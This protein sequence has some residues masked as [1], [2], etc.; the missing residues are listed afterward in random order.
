M[1]SRT[2]LFVA[3]SELHAL[4]CVERL[5][6]FVFFSFLLDDFKNIGLIILVFD[7]PKV[8]SNDSMQT[9][10]LTPDHNNPCLNGFLKEQTHLF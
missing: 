1:V 6:T 7:P 3:R 5:D 2:N 4:I 9:A 10:L 8:V